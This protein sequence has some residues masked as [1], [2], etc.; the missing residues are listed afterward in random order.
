VGPSSEGDEKRLVE[1]EI[2]INEMLK[3]EIKV[4]LSRF[5]MICPLSLS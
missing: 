3:S 5:I 2:N 1:K 4:P